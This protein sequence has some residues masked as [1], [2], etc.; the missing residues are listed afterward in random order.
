MLNAVDQ[1]APEGAAGLTDR[2][3]ALLN[4]T[5]FPDILGPLGAT[6][7]I[8][9]P[10]PDERAAA[11]P[12]V[13]AV[14]AVGAEDPG[15]VAARADQGFSGTGFVI[16]PDHVLTNAHVV[17]GASTVAV[18]VE[19]RVGGGDGRRLRP[20]AGPR[21]A[22]RAGARPA[23][24]SLSTPSC[25]R[26]SPTRSCSAT[27]WAD[28]SPSAPAGSGR[29][30]ELSGPD[31]YQSTTVRR[32]VYL[33]RASVRPGNSGGPVIDATGEVIGVVFGAAI[34]DPDTGFALT[35]AEVA[36]TVAGR[37]D[38]HLAPPRP[39]RVRAAD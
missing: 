4:S 2:L 10:A 38:R 28:R 16:G 18:E 19:R 14:G 31:I 32:Q 20:R 13:A 8:D 11:D 12:V 1:V 25:S 23:R 15:G 17:G 21:G 27:R 3:R 5:G 26:R 7:D 22:V 24:C 9:V 36:E 33:L 29:S 35:A 37:A 6:P 30:T 34:D 39:G